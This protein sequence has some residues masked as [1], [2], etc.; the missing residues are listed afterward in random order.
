MDGLLPVLQVFRQ[1]GGGGSAVVAED[2][3]DADASGYAQAVDLGLRH[4]VVRVSHGTLQFIGRTLQRALSCVGLS[5]PAMTGDPR[6]TPGFRQQ[7]RL[8]QAQRLCAR[9]RR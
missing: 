6:F 5:P 4:V 1:V 8:I 7:G 3:G 2:L 9:G